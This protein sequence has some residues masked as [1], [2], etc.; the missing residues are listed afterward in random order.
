MLHTPDPD[1]TAPVDNSENIERLIGVIRDGATTRDR[2]IVQ[3]DRYQAS[4]D[5][6]GQLVDELSQT[7]IDLG[8]D[9]VHV[10]QAAGVL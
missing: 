2:L 3:R 9:P 7:V 10:R 6:W 4:A 1:S 8:G 5:R